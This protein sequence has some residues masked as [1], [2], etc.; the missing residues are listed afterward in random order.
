IME[1]V[2]RMINKEVVLET[3]V[4]TSILGGLIIRVG[5]KLLDGSTKNKL[6]SLKNELEAASMRRAQS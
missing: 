6:L 4:D 5:D 3:V 2:R 1:Y